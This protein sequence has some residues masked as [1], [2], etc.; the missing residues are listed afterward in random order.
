MGESRV[1]KSW[2]RGLQAGRQ[3]AEWGGGMLGSSMLSEEPRDGGARLFV[4]GR[5]RLVADV[6]VHARLVVR[7]ELAQQMRV[8]GLRAHGEGR[9][10]GKFVGR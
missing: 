3:H 1:V 4:L 5:E 2:S 7:G 6:Q 8:E 9:D 10:A